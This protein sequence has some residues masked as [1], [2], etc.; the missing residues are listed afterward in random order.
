[1]IDEAHGREE[2]MSVH[3]ELQAVIDAVNARGGK[4]FWELSPTEARESIRK[5]VSLFGGPVLQVPRVESLS[6]PGPDGEALALRLYAPH[7]EPP[8]TPQPLLIY[9]HGGGFVVG[10]IEVYDRLCRRL[11]LEA[12][13]LVLSVDYR[14]APEHRF[15]AAVE[16]CQ[17]ALHWAH[18]NAERLGADPKRIAVGGDS[19]GGN[20]AAVVSQQARAEG[21][22][23][24]FQMLIYPATGPSKITP[25][26]LRHAEGYMLTRKDLNYFMAHYVNGEFAS[27]IDDPRARPLQAKD[28]S[29][30]PP[31][32]LF[33]AGYDPLHDEG[34][35]YAERLQEAGVPVQVADW[36]GAIHGCFT[37]TV[38]PY[39][40]RA[41]SDAAKALH[42]T[43]HGASSS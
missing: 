39:C 9:Y 5:G 25:S 43:F 22:S 18:A 6:M 38:S 3:P 20:L 17:A 2:I 7:A 1:M 28:F 24:C 37:Y 16:D 13:C 32:Y 10:D 4:E 12:N 34:L 36:P 27:V 30:L 26:I 33:V 42:R 35:A 14:L 23:I 15:P 21:P 41:V 29:G 19:A 31:A 11:T 8:A 40:Q